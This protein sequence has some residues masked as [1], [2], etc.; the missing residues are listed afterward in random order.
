MKIIF[1]GSDD[2]AK[3][4]LEYL[5]KSEHEIVACVTQPD[6]PKGR[7]LAVV[8]SP[9]KEWAAQ[10][11]IPVLQ[12]EQIKNNDLIVKLRAFN[13]D[14]FV[15]IAYGKI[16]PPELL[17]IPYVCAMN[18]HGSLLPKLRG[19]APINWAI[20]NGEK[21]TGLS[22]IKMSPLMDSGDIFAQ[23]KIKIEEV[24]TAVT[25]RAKMVALGP[26]LLL[27]TINSLENNNYTLT[28]Q[29]SRAVTLASKLTKELGRI[30]WNKKAIEIH[31]LV[32]G[33]LPW[34]CAHT[35]FKGKLLKIISTEVIMQDVST[36]KPGVIVDI[37]QKGLLV[38]TAQNCLL[39]KE[40]HLES[41][42][43]MGAKI[44]LLG[45]R[46]DVGFKFE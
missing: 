19:A 6:K 29:D 1:F 21:E 41:S 20:I 10:H 35:L 27:K 4:H 9:I 8:S 42:K 25:L 31:N 3:A 46:I 32:R 34:P 14:L 24:D 33:L 2:F 39:I 38:A 11:K 18:V 15:V 23:T 28:V 30:D 37:N 22:I 40:V 12:P 45:H 16:L 13:P 7:G 43:P 26:E 36:R 44:F 17:Q 5:F